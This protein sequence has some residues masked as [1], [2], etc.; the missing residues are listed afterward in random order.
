MRQRRPLRL[1]DLDAVVREAES[2]LASGYTR[3]GAWGLGQ[4]AEHLARAI[5]QSMDG[6]PSLLPA[7][8]RWLIRWMALGKILRHEVITRKVPAPP[9][10]RPADGVEDRAGVERLRAAV[11]RFNAHAGPLHPSPAFGKL[12]R[13]QWREVHVW[14]SEHHLS[15]LHPRTNG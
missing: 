6:Y 13:E 10:M 15:H 3:G 5:E 8:V 2:L 14:H 11:A 1:P 9:Y 7:P 12:T 4:N